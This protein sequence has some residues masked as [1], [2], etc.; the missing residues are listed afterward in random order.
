MKVNNKIIST[1]LLFTLFITL[2]CHIVFASDNKCDCVV[3]IPTST[4]ENDYVKLEGIPMTID[5]VNSNVKFGINIHKKNGITLLKAG[6]FQITNSDTVI[7]EI[8]TDKIKGD[9]VYYDLRNN[10]TVCNVSNNELPVEEFKIK[11]TDKPNGDVTLEITVKQSVLTPKLFC[12]LLQM[13]YVTYERKDGS[14]DFVRGEFATTSEEQ[15]TQLYNA[16]EPVIVTGKEPTYEEDGYNIL[17]CKLCGK[18]L[19][20]IPVP[21][22]TYSDGQIIDV[23]TCSHPEKIETDKVTKTESDVTFTSN[24]LSMSKIKDNDT[25]YSFSG[26]FNLKVPSS[27]KITSMGFICTTANLDDFSIYNDNSSKFS[28]SDGSSHGTF[29]RYDLVTNKLFFGSDNYTMINA[30]C[31]LSSANY[32]CCGYSISGDNVKLTFSGASPYTGLSIFT[33]YVQLEDGSYVYGYPVHSDWDSKFFDKDVKVCQSDWVLEKDSSCEDWGYFEK[34]CLICGQIVS[35]KM[36]GPKGHTSSNWIIDSNSTCVIKGHAHKECLT[37]GKLLEEKDLELSNHSPVKVISKEPSC[38]EEGTYKIICEVCGDEL[39][40]GSIPKTEHD[41]EEKLINPTCVRNGYTIHKCKVCGYYYND[42]YTPNSPHTPSD[43]KLVKEA[44]CE[45]EGIEQKICTECNEVLE[46]RNTPKLSHV[47]GNWFIL[48]E[49][50]C[51]TEGL[52]VRNCLLCGYREERVVSPKGHSLKVITIEPTCESRG[53]DLIMCEECGYKEKTNFT[54]KINHLESDWIIS[55]KPSCSREGTRFKYCLLCGK[56]TRTESIKDL[57]HSYNKTIIKP[58]CSG[59][60]YDSYVCTRCGYSYKDNYSDE[61]PHTPSGW[62]VDKKPT[63]FDFG[64]KYKIC[65]VCGKTLEEKSIGTLSALLPNLELNG[66]TVEKK[67]IVSIDNKDKVTSNK[68]LPKEVRDSENRIIKSNNFISLS[69]SFDGIIS[70]VI[71]F[72]NPEVVMNKL[73][74]EDLKDDLIYTGKYNPNESVIQPSV[75]L[76]KDYAGYWVEYYVKSENGMKLIAVSQINS[77]GVVK[78]NVSNSKQTLRMIISKEYEPDK[79]YE[80]IYNKKENPKT[81]RIK[82]VVNKVVKFF[83]NL[84]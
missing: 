29:M 5:R 32:G 74:I 82:T 38:V 62:I 26:S 23:K 39:G 11:R 36:I 53:Y 20:R 35:K 41:Y 65:L 4:F 33:P 45:N 21:K 73:T 57:G 28:E 61:L 13:A 71:D 79:M 6:L 55:K 7:E 46:V 52:E 54:D 17:M 8:M 25:L 78:V 12:R 48:N 70:N 34:T 76:G 19:D 81:S 47:F 30:D 51:T 58:S 16:Y 2:N 77:D 64:H 68:V 69:K 40:S 80:K 50:S 59:N 75:D 15:I 44:T 67:I 72:N 22:L 42:N 60:G 14:F 84:F 27:V 63:A 10:I 83:R 31:N 56:T 37:C 1:L 66:N 9:N 3:S 24:K 49:P 18:E 43:W